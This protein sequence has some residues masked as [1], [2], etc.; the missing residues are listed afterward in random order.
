MTYSHNRIEV[1]YFK[2]LAI[3]NAAG[4]GNTISDRSFCIRI[5]PVQE[6]KCCVRLESC[7]AKVTILSSSFC[8]LCLMLFWLSLIRLFYQITVQFPRVQK[9]LQCFIVDPPILRICILFLESSL[10]LFFS[11]SQ[12]KECQIKIAATNKRINQ[13]AW[14][15]ICSSTSNSEEL[16]GCG[17]WV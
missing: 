8:T 12:C 6:F 7:S 9:H 14:V 17:A 5:H 15:T 1:S 13:G 10:F 2:A 4:N 16:L 11:N 3:A